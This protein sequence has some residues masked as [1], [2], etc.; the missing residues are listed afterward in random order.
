[1]EPQEASQISSHLESCA[2]CAAVA[3][4]LAETQEFVEGALRT[5]VTAPS[6][7]QLRVM[8]AVNASAGRRDRNSARSLLWNRRRRFA[9][10]S[11]ALGL[12]AGGYLLG[13]W[14]GNGD[15]RSI[16]VLPH[17]KLSTLP[18]TLLGEDHLEYLA[19]PQPAQVL[20][21]DPRAVSRGMTPLMKF[22]VAAIDLQSM[23]ARLLG[24][25]RCVLRGVAVAFLLYDW[26]GERVSL[27]QIDE[28]K[29]ALPVMRE[30]VFRGRTFR[31]GEADG[32]FYVS[33]RSG[34]MSFVLVSGAEPGRLLRLACHA[35]GMRESA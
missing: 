34:A 12:L 3:E 18:L 6:T 30:T 19:N 35:S 14:H 32:L 29:I 7:L 17:A 5:T 9:A 21:P 20:G 25:R 2:R 31:V 16:S 8:A 33:W 10:A 4:E 11:A 22:P 15:P 24:G 26:R 27:Y 23:G 28:R 1:V 13:H